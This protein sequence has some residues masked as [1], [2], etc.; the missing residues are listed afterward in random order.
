MTKATKAWLFII[1][2]PVPLYFSM[3]V[4]GLIGLAGYLGYYMPL[5][6]MGETFFNYSSDIGWYFPSLYGQL[7]AAVIYSVAYWF[8]YWIFIKLRN[9]SN[10]H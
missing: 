10:N 1:L 9:V 4:L 8:G 2:L 5:W 6:K 3:Y 7:A